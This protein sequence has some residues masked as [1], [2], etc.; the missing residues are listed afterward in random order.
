MRRRGTALLRKV[1]DAVRERVPNR[2]NVN[3]FDFLR[4]GGD[5]SR[6]LDAVRRELRKTTM[7][8]SIRGNLPD[9][10]PPS[11]QIHVLSFEGPDSYSR[12]GGIATRITG[13]CD[14][15]ASMG[16]ETHLWF[17]GDPALPG[18]ERMGLLHLHRWCQWISRFHPSGVYDGEDGKTQDYA[19]SLPPFIVDH[20]LGP[21]L[22]RGGQAIVL[23]EEWHT[24]WAVQHLHWLLERASLRPRVC[25]LWNANNTFGFDRID[26]Q[27]LSSASV[28]TTVS[29]YMKHKMQPLGVDPLV[30]P[31]GLA[32]DV[33]APID[34]DAAA[35]F[36]EKL[37]GRV[38]LAKVARF[39][40][41]KRWHQAI[42]IVHEMKREGKKPL[43]IARGGLEPHGAEVLERA[44]GMGLKIIDRSAP[45]PG[46]D[47]LVE[48]LDNVNGADIV[49]LKTHVDSDARRLLF[50]ESNAVL[51]NSA[52]EPFGLV[53]LEA[54]A[55]QGV[56]VTG[57]SGEDYAVPGRNAV[58]L[59]TADPREFVGLYN[60]LLE[61]PEREAELRLAARRTAKEYAWPEVVK[62][63][64]LPRLD[65]LRGSVR[66]TAK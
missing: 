29:R 32:P 50:S 51:A 18:H 58:V 60:Q 3:P 49:N 1:L 48:A 28:I 44:S 65:L 14:A 22:R 54:M 20:Y 63:N 10:I 40:P 52:H 21:H 56:A 57:F 64:V 43:L 62:R 33:F 45:R 53:G 4:V 25:M 13:L 9:V 42:D 61:S 39:D 7:A 15:L 8:S 23:A 55:A 27:A 59:Q 66:S 37:L 35:R 41:D 36:R 24:V 47:G 11:V 17:V 12:A 31:N 38:A 19:S 6:D 5:S 16:Y 26:W 30:L 46:P 34:S 2:L